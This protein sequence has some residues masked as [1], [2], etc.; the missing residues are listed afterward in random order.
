MEPDPSDRV[1]DVTIFA[2]RRATSTSLLDILRDLS[3]LGL[4]RRTHVVDVDSIRP[5][6]LRVPCWVVE[7]GSAR[8][9]ILQ[10]NLASSRAVERVRICA[11][12]E[13]AETVSSV[14]ADEAH[15]LQGVVRASLPQ[16]S[17]TPV[18]AVGVS[19]QGAPATEELAW[20][21]WHNVVT[22]PENSPAPTAGISPIVASDTT[23]RRTHLVVSLCSLMGLWRD[24]GGCPFDSRPLLPGRMIIASRSYIRHLSA[25]EVED[26]LLRRLVCMTEG[27]PVPSLDGA[28]AWVIED[29]VTAVTEMADHLLDKYR[30]VMPRKREMPRS[31]SPKPIGAL[32]AIKLL[33][34]FLW[35]VLKNA[36]RAF[37][38]AAVNRISQQAASLVG[39][40]VFGTGDSEYIVVVKGVRSDGRPASWA[41][42][43]EA[44][45]SAAARLG[46]PRMTEGSNADLSN[47][48]KDFVHA[49]LTLMDAGSRTPDLPPLTKGGRSAVVGAVD[50]VAPDPVDTYAPTAS[51]A[52]HIKGW[53]LSSNDVVQTRLLD[54]ELGA[55][56]E[57]QP[58]LRSVVEKDRARLRE[59][60]QPRAQSFSGRVGSTLGRAV[61]D[62]RKEIAGLVDELG[63]AVQTAAVP[64][65]IAAEQDRLAKTLRLLLLVT[66]AVVVGVIALVALGPLT[67]MIGGI[68]C[69]VVVISWLVSSLL[70]FMKG[71]R[72]LFAMLHRREELNT[73]IEVLRRHLA[74]AIEDLRRLS[75]AYRQYLDWSRALGAFVQAPLGSAPVEGDHHLVVGT[76]LPRNCRIGLA[77]P[78]Q[79]VIDEVAMLL[80]RDLFTVGWASDFWG[81]FIAD[82][83]AELGKDAYRVRADSELLWSDPGI[84]RHSVLTA[85]S[86]AIVARGIRTGAAPELRERVSELLSSAHPDLATRLLAQVE[87]RSF[88]TADLEILDYASFMS[89][90]DSGQRVGA[91][92]AFDRQMFASAPQV[93]EPWQV[94]ETWT[95]EPSRRLS[96]TVVVT[97]LSS[98]FYGYDLEL[99]RQTGGE[100]LELAPS[101]SGSAVRPPM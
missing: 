40:T 96:R 23:L 91:D 63:R 48:W 64:D 62:T 38:D 100:P 70:T 18:H 2:A 58:H 36:P 27:L 43:D 16:V 34:T 82:V 93:S 57:S 41:E 42:V 15:S 3:A 67:L 29:E 12:T 81:L 7:D 101:S 49:A 17:I 9:E 6:D 37:L 59:W 89:G 35:N 83:P 79:P 53:Q 72:N 95:G 92:Q 77:H 73:Q 4:V 8:V 28:S 1:C 78:E 97:Q 50:R 13:A 14:T 88:G 56:A 54:D 65:A 68:V 32:T 80:K 69:L 22:A 39:S 66:V 21:G 61:R 11:L 60:F 33:F 76:G 31:T 24:E 10:D 94:A 90:L 87:T 45:A 19:L 51:V 47:L 74:D 20:L 26:E 30:H 98:G 5:G 99:G 84:A 44:V 55:L 86:H 75:R 46:V 85:W 25:A 71:Q 52:G